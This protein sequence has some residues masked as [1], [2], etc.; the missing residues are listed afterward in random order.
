MRIAVATDRE[1]VAE[2]FGC[3]PAC[4]LFDIQDGVVHEL[5]VL[6][7]PGFPHTFWG[8]LFV[9]NSVTAVFAGTMGQL[10]QS[11]LKGWN[12]QVILGVSGPVA[13]LLTRVLAEGIP[14]MAV[15]SPDAA[16]QPAACC[17]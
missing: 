10:N 6:P 15:A 2:H 1:F 16:R 11:I 14:A 9:R 8:D 17:C 13:D 3:A 4:T 7:N 12:I 5:L